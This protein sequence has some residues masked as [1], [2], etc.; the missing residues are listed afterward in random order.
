ML[1]A[2]EQHQSSLLGIKTKGKSKEVAIPVKSI[3]EMDE[4]D[5][6]AEETQSEDDSE[7]D[8]VNPASQSL[9]QSSDSANEIPAVIK[10][11][12][13]KTGPTII[14]FSE[15][16]ATSIGTNKDMR[17]FMVSSTTF[18]STPFAHSYYSSPQKSRI[19]DPPSP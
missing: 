12:L 9:S 15:P 10:A 1:F 13:I 11:K 6:N 2:L 7:E 4:N 3:W 17:N 19:L 14:S 18:S 16:R 8:S 5:F